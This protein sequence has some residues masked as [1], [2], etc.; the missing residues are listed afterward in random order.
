M[1]R[2]ALMT[3]SNSGASDGDHVAT[4]HKCFVGKLL[5]TH[6]ADIVLSVYWSSRE[7]SAYCEPNYE[8]RRREQKKFA[9][10]N[11]GKTLEVQINK[12]FFLLVLAC[13]SF[14]QVNQMIIVRKFIVRIHYCHVRKMLDATQKSQIFDHPHLALTTL[15]NAPHTRLM[16]MLW[17]RH[18]RKFSMYD[19]SSVPEICVSLTRASVR[20]SGVECEGGVGLQV[21]LHLSYAMWRFRVIAGQNFDCFLCVVVFFRALVHSVVSASSPTISPSKTAPSDDGYSPSKCSGKRKSYASSKSNTLKA[22]RTSC[23]NARTRSLST[24]TG[25]SRT[26]SLCI[27]SWSLCWA[28]RSSHNCV[29]AVDSRMKRHVS[30]PLKLCWPLRAYTSRCAFF[31]RDS[32]F[33]LCSKIECD[34]ATVYNM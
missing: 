20:W 11:C 28:A 29:R 16:L 1:Y 15:N 34:T 5:M 22:K 7:R 9:V 31:F 24:C 17:F 10:S 25:G 13:N 14:I 27:W 2:N 21:V 26:P 6:L 30:L 12:L 33:S 4:R 3:K 32:I 19:S 8:L 18:E 23:H